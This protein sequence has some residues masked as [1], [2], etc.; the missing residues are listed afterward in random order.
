MALDLSKIVN[1]ITGMVGS[2]KAHRDERQQQ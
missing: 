1:Q 2:L